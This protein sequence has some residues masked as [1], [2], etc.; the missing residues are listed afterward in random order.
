[1]SGAV[2]VCEQPSLTFR[3]SEPPTDTLYLGAMGGVSYWL[4]RM[5]PEFIAQALGI[6]TTWWLGWWAAQYASGDPRNV[7]AF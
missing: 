1:M 5:S 7:N 2:H 6:L 3:C 4:Q